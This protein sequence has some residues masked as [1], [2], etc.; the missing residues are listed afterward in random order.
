MCVDEGVQMGGRG[1]ILG[2]EGWG[3]ASE[4][5]GRLP[6]LCSLWPGALQVGLKS[7]VALGVGDPALRPVASHCGWLLSVRRGVLMGSLCLHD[8]HVRGNR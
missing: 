7:R 1:G 8:R 4:D 6:Q 3:R 2:H 5:A